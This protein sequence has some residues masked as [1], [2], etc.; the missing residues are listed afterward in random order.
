MSS[1]V[2]AARLII[3]SGVTHN[4]PLLRDVVSHSRFIRGE[5]TT[6]FLAEEYPSGFKGHELTPL[7]TRN[8]SAVIASVW[9]ELESVCSNWIVGAGS[10]G[11]VDSA[12]TQSDELVV[13]LGECDSTKLSVS[14]LASGEFRVDISGE[15]FTT[16]LDWTTEGSLIRATVTGKDGVAHPITAQY[17]EKI[18]LG[19]RVSFYGTKV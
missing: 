16:K 1:R 19:L 15:S 7:D 3:Y 17:L 10:F 13:K 14:K 4:I 11:A 8:L 9:I 2:S 5:L 18:P 12:K 6:S